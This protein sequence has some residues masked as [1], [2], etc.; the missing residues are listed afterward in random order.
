VVDV[1]EL[2]PLASIQM[3]FPYIQAA[4]H[5]YGIHPRR[6]MTG[7]VSYSR[8]LGYIKPQLMRATEGEYR[9]RRQLVAR[10]WEPRHLVS[11]LGK[12]I[13]ALSPHADDESIGAGG[14]LL[15]HRGLSEIHLVCLCDGAGGGSLGDADTNPNALVE[16]RRGEF[17][18]AAA[19]LGATSVQQLDYPSGNI[20]C[21]A[22]AAE[23]LRSMVREIEP[24]VVVLPW[25]L[26]GH[27]DHKSANALYARA[28][29]DIKATVLGYEIWTMLEPNAVFDITPHLADKLS[30]I[31]NYP[32]QLRTVDYLGYVSGL[33]TVRAYHAALRP[34]RSGAAEAFVAL[35][36]RE[37]CELVA[38]LHAEELPNAVAALE[39][40]RAAKNESHSRFVPFA[41]DPFGGTEVFVSN[42]AG[43]L[44]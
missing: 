39:T 16:A 20:P 3:W 38:Q 33:A 11:P 13:L 36:N 17:L 19:A 10:A 40:F 34:L 31:R 42:L 35:P 29:G 32:S 27:V 5:R 23:R 15:A 14:L 41:P 12:R 30:L 7:L 18:N 1:A 9:V 22:A 8:Y 43:D 21:T 6:W 28:C 2:S 25:F 4:F 24:D 44:R 26:D 37:Y